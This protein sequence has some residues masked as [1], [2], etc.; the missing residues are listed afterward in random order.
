MQHGQKIFTI[1]TC[2]AGGWFC[3]MFASRRA[4]W[5]GPSALHDRR[6]GKRS[7]TNTTSVFAIGIPLPT[8]TTFLGAHLVRPLAFGVDDLGFRVF[9]VRLA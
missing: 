2:I 3:G 5:P 9:I 1:G 8:A 4:S 7:S 6:P